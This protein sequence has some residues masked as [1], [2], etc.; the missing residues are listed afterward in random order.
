VLSKARICG[1]SLAGV[2]G[3]ITPPAACMSVLCVVSQD[4]QVKCRTIQDK[5][6]A[7]LVGRS[8]DRSPVVSL[9]IFPKLPTEPYAVGSTLALEMSTRKTPG[10]EGGRCVRVTTLP[11]SYFRKSRRFR[12]LNLLE[13]Q[14]PHQACSGKPL[15][16]PFFYKTKKQLQMKYEQSTTEFKTFL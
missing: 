3:S 8:R 14:E 6:T 4:K 13:P 7:P 15:P 10:G 16:F 1:Q 5:S 11:P 9:G 2:V 12:S